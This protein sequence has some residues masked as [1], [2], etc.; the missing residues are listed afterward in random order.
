MIQERILKEI[1][2]CASESIKVRSVPKGFRISFPVVR[3]YDQLI[4]LS[5]Q[6]I[7]EG[8][9]RVTDAG[10]LHTW[11]DL[12]GIEAT[13]GPG[14][15]AISYIRDRG[16][17]EW[18]D[19]GGPELGWQ[20]P[21]AD[22]GCIAWDLVHELYASLRI[23]QESVREVQKPYASS[24]VNDVIQKFPNTFKRDVR[25]GSLRF[26]LFSEAH[27]VAA[28]VV[29]SNAE[30]VNPFTLAQRQ[31]MP[32][33]RAKATGQKW[34]RLA[35]VQEKFKQNLEV[36]NLL[37]DAGATTISSDGFLKPLKNYV[38]KLRNL[39]DYE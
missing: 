5:F 15:H 27:G 28:V 7:A 9:I 16:F 2:R 3:E 38:S 14:Q 36:R 17:E 20:G 10:M 23:A 22:I 33:M 19:R 11:L 6:E 24:V 18:S 8:E 35:L 31:V 12:D 32:I 34:H 1:M 4:E 30:N 39:N 13:A 21:I 29:G 25:K 26:P 37:E